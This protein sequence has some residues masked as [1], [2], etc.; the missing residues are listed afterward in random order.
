[1][2]HICFIVLAVWFTYSQLIIVY[3]FHSAAT[4]SKQV[5]SHT[6]EF[7]NLFNFI[8]VNFVFFYVKTK[9]I[10]THLHKINYRYSPRDQMSHAE[11]VSYAELAKKEVNFGIQMETT[12]M[13]LLHHSIGLHAGGLFVIDNRILLKVNATQSS[14]VHLSFHKCSCLQ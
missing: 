6:R 4:L 13:H 12:Q 3:L 10:R 8:H 5:M 9:H 11:V 1:M 7:K 2:N 14:P